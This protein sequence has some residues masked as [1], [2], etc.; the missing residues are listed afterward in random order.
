M[1]KERMGLVR[2]LRAGDVIEFTRDGERFGRIVAI[3]DDRI[4]IA[5]PPDIRIVTSTEGRSDGRA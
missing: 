2:E 5:F 1:S 4:A 3:D